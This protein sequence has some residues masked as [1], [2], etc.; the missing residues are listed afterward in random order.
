MLAAQATREQRLA[1][2]DD[3]IRNDGSLADLERAVDDLHLRYL[4]MSARCHDT[5]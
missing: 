3:V 1:I 5:P 4:A 2:A